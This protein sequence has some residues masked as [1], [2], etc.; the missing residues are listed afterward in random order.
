MKAKIWQG[1]FALGLIALCLL[2]GAVDKQSVSMGQSLILSAVCLSGMYIGAKQGGMMPEKE[3][4]PAR[5][6]P[7]KATYKNIQLKY[8]R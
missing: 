3:K 5:R 6:Q 2:P 8:N 7:C 1:T 4:R